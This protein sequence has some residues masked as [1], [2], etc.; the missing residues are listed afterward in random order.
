MNRLEEVLARKDV[1]DPNKLL[2]TSVSNGSALICPNCGGTESHA[3]KVFALR[4]TDHKEGGVVPDI[5]VLGVSEG[6]RR[7]AVVI[8]FTCENCPELFDIIFQQ[9]KG[10]TF[11]QTKI[12]LGRSSIEWREQESAE[13]IYVET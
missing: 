4:G 12:V 9:H 10:N 8:R 7:A 11:V 5:P 1:D 3:L 13:T 2:D 6:K